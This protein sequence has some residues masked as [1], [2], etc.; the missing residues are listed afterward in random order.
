MLDNLHNGYWV[1]VDKSV[2]PSFPVLVLCEK[3]LN[4]KRQPFED[5]DI[6]L[7]SMDELADYKQFS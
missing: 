4:L 2:I 3:A 5:I 7:A 6:C 1:P